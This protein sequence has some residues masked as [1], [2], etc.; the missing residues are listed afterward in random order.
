MDIV[1]LY[2]LV[3]LG[4][5]IF[6]SVMDYGEKQHLKGYREGFEEGNRLYKESENGNQ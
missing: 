2:V 5:T 6:I 4:V 3:F 1:I